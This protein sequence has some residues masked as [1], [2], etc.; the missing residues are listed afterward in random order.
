MNSV[1]ILGPA[2]ESVTEPELGMAPTPG[3]RQI[4][5]DDLPTAPGGKVFMKLLP[6]VQPGDATPIAVYAFYV[7][8]PSSV[9]APAD[10]TPEWFF[11]SGAPNGSTP[12]SMFGPD[13]TFSIQVPGVKPGVYLCQ[14]IL[15]FAS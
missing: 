3:R 11:S 12:A 8:P 6:P 10:R 15:E 9:P 13:G 1:F 5:F 2:I 14:S 4:A 7:S